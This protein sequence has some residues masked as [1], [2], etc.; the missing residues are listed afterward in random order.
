[1]NNEHSACRL[2]LAKAEQEAGPS[3]LRFVDLREKTQREYRARIME[4]L[5]YVK[6]TCRDVNGRYSLNRSRVLA[7]M[8]HVARGITTNQAAAWFSCVNQFLKAGSG[9]G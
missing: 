5:C 7:W 1:M 3:L 6:R 4:F 2:H 8:H 9:S